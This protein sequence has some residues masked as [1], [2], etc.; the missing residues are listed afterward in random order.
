MAALTAWIRALPP[1]RTLN[2]TP[3]GICLS[4]FVFLTG[5]IPQDSHNLEWEKGFDRHPSTL[6]LEAIFVKQT[7][8]AIV[9]TRRLSWCLP[10]QQRT[11]NPNT[12]RANS[13][14]LNNK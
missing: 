9:D 13:N 2:L 6:F 4:N 14:S 11:M 8:Y 12:K 10:E 5:P 3:P 1:G 7:P